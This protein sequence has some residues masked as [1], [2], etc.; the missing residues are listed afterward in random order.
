MG[1]AAS[2]I[3][4]SNIDALLVAGVMTVNA[5]TGGVQRLRAEAA[6]AELFAE[7]DQLVRRVVVPAV[8]TTR[9]RLEAARHDPATVSAKSLR[10]GDVI[11]LADPEVDPAG[12]APAG[13]RRPR[14]RRVL[15]YRRVAT[16]GQA[17]GPRRRQRP[18]PGQHAV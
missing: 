17:G 15:S 13:G 12:C 6:A 9:R 10:V 5:I 1:A 3:V 8:A 16:G 11:D 2:A 7:Q 4:G 18:R 14:G